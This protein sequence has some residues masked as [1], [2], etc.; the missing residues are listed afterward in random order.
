MES[1]ESAA[2][3]AV[4][5]VGCRPSSFARCP[6]VQRLSRMAIGSPALPPQGRSR[7]LPVCA[8]IPS[9]PTWRPPLIPD[10]LPSVAERN[11]RTTKKL[12]E[13]QR[14]VSRLLYSQSTKTV[15]NIAVSCG[16]LIPSII[17]QSDSTSGWFHFFFSLSFDYDDIF[18]C[19]SYK[20]RTEEKIGREDRSF[21]VWSYRKMKIFIFLIVYCYSIFFFL[22]RPS[23]PAFAQR[24]EEDFRLHVDGAQ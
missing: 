6:R 12:R 8:F 17:W 24:K 11:E 23:L 22:R 20:F 7:L 3:V 1:K 5:G 21:V 18:S 10:V 13:N 4:A 16:I 9:R 19:S 15:N 14:L 2:T